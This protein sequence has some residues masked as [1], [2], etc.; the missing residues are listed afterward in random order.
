MSV[1]AL[2]G[3]DRIKSAYARAAAEKVPLLLLRRHLP[4]RTPQVTSPML[5]SA[6]FSTARCASIRLRREVDNN[7]TPQVV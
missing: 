2:A 1:A 5:A 3:L 4:N 6:D 7:L